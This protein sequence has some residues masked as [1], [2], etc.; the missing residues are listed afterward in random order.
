M[1]VYSSS[2]VE[3]G[4]SVDPQKGSFRGPFLTLFRPPLIISTPFHLKKFKNGVFLVRKMSPKKGQD[5][6]G[7]VVFGG[8][9]GG[10]FWGSRG[11]VG[12]SRIKI[13][14]KSN[15]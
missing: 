10:P 11:I 7:G 13:K 3:D 12:F 1:C 6:H 4:A 14:N 15:E 5:A 9:G 2:F 8:L